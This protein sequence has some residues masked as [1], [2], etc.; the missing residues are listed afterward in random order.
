M[1]TYRLGC[2]LVSAVCCLTASVTHAQ[3]KV[4]GRTQSSA[5]T[6]YRFT[7]APRIP[8][9]HATPT[10]HATGCPCR[11]CQHAHPAGCPCPICAKRVHVTDMWHGFQTAPLF[12]WVIDD[13]FY[14]RSPDY[15]Y[16]R[17]RKVPIERRHFS[18]ERYWPAKW[19]GQ[20]GSG[21]M[22]QHFPTVAV[23]TDTT[24]LGYY[25][26]PVPQWQ[27]NSAKIP[28]A[29]HPLQYHFRTKCPPMPNRPCPH[30]IVWIR[31]APEQQPAAAPADQ[32][33]V[34]PPAPA[35]ES[36]TPPEPEPAKPT[37]EDL[38][39]SAARTQ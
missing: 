38:K 12:R 2:T 31:S 14:T 27:P 35:V 6:D 16:I 5:A 24:Q 7:V 3:D 30:N 8:V 28:P 20:P 15:G 33:I 23:P 10:G 11:Q 13:G 18:Y 32:P 22:S 26:Q 17:V 9:S 36:N 21:Q 25:Y 19:Y 29:P 4:R 37:P 39:K 34:P 1:N